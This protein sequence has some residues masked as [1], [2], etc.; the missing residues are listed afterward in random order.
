M[1]TFKESAADSAPTTETD[2]FSAEPNFINT[3]TSAIHMKAFII[4]SVKEKVLII[5]HIQGDGDIKV[6]Q[7]FTKK[8]KKNIK[9]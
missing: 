3:N 6:S 2:Q 9:S 8:C 7:T 4:F 1:S 5:K